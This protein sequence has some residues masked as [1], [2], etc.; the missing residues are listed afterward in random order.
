MKKRYIFLICVFLINVFYIKIRSENKS[1]I[2][3]YN[4][5]SLK[6]FNQK[7]NKYTQIELQNLFKLLAQDIEEYLIEK[8]TDLNK[9]RIINKGKDIQ[10]IEILSDTQLQLDDLFIAEG[11][12]YAKKNNL[13]LSA[14]KLQYDLKSKTINIDGEIYFKVEDQYLIAKS[15][16]YNIDKKRGYI[17]DA[18][19]SLNFENIGLIN[20]GKESKS[21]SNETIIKDKEIKN[22][23]LNKSS[24]I[25]FEDIDYFKENK[26]IFQKISSQKL[27]LDLN[28][29]QKWRFQAEK[30]IINENI[31]SSDKLY[32]TNDPFDSPQLV[33]E[34]I[35]FRSINEDG[36]IIIKSKWSSI[37]LDDKVNIPAGP[38]RIKIGEENKKGSWGFGYDKNQKDGFFINRSFA[39]IILND[40]TYINL[41]KDF[42]LQRTL[43][44]KTK[45]FSKKGASILD[46]KEEQDINFED[47]F[48][49]EAELY[50]KLYGFD[51]E[52][53][54]TL[55]S[56]DLDKLNKSLRLKAELSKILFKEENEKFKKRIKL[57]FFESYREKVWN[58]SLGERDILNAFGTRI[59]REHNWKEKKVSKSSIISG[60]YG[61]YEA[62]KRTD[63]SKSIKRKRLNIFLERNHSYPLWI[64]S[65]SSKLNDTHKYNPQIIP[66]GLN[67]NVFSKVDL[68]HYDDDNFQRLLSLK[69]GP[70]LTIGKFKKKFFDYTKLSLYPKT[71]LAM[72]NS[73]FS[74]DQAVDNHSIEISLKQQLIGAL[75]LKYTSE[76]NLDINS[77][78]FHKFFNNKY[79]LSWNRRAYKLSIYY[80]LEQK[81]GGFKFKIYSFKFDGYGDKFK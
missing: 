53:N 12:V 33:I 20:I 81:A 4:L 56:L 65:K 54:L 42:Y 29:M 49:L 58:G 70:E 46:P 27:K 66:Q 51:L 69:A 25:G 1:N 62:S 9:E 60:A 73:P 78:K 22:V 80:N 3:D 36:N 39:P 19:G 8:K 16:Q 37:K 10:S 67:L 14:N 17:I 26:T 2:E 47:Y 72:G 35:G 59:K 55:N 44:G 5:K 63:N 41:T 21:D 15:I 13:F 43:I 11:N 34:S 31:W 30:I 23:Y 7:G 64:S 48:G 74:F 76:Y 79:E 32:L 6:F 50:S 24:S 45:S 57:T 28:E 52:S 71:T 18:Y 75:A 61:Y 38:R 77:K 40:A 68:Y